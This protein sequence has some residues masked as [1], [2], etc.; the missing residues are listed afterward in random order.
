[1]IKFAKLEALGNDFIL[2]DGRSDAMLPDPRTLAPLA[3]RRRGIGFD[4]AL[5]LCSA[6]H[7]SDSDSDSDLIVRIFNSDGSEAEQ[8]GN[9]M[10]AIAAWFDARGELG[11]GLRLETL[12]GTVSISAA[13]AGMYAAE[14]PGARPPEAQLAGLELPEID[15]PGCLAGLASVGNPHLVIH[16]PH[17]PTAADLAVV[18]AR[19][20]ADPQWCNRVNV[21]LASSSD[22]GSRIV[23]RVHE[24]GAG[25]TPACGSGAC[26][27]ALLLGR[28][29]APVQVEQ[30][31]GKLVIDWLPDHSRVRTFGPAHL[32]FHGSTA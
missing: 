11:A 27:A 4:Q 13:S 19:I 1:M 8:C 15:A 6:V 25:P 3:D 20:G 16:W 14:L 30:P 31:G 32:V 21:G 10:R 23:L 26:A 2:V 17:P 12:A 18:A 29:G 5:L 7:D 28:P 22:G 9:G 24:R